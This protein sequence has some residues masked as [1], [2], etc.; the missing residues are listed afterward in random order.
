MLKSYYMLRK[1]R[2][3]HIYK[4]DQDRK[5][6]V[7]DKLNGFLTQETPEPVLWLTRL[8]KKQQQAITYKE[9][10]EAIEH[11]AISEARVAQWQQ[12]YASFVN[13]KLKPK[14]EKAIQTGAARVNSS[15]F[16]F[17]PTD[18]SIQAWI[19]GHGAQLVTNITDSQR[20][21]IN[22]LVSHSLSSNW[23]VDE[24]ARA[25]R[26]V[27]G[28][29]RPQAAANLRY[30]ERI[31]ENLLQQNPT[32]RL[33]TAGKKAQAAAHIYAQRQHQQRAYTIATTELAYAYN[34]GTDFA[35][36]QAMELGYIGRTMRIWS[37][38]RAERVCDIC[39]SLDG[40][41]IGMEDQFGLQGTWYGDVPPAHPHCRCAVLYHEVEP[42]KQ[43]PSGLLSSENIP[44]PFLNLPSNPDA[45]NNTEP[46]KPFVLADALVDFKNRLQSVPE[47]NRMLLEY[48]INSTQFVLNTKIDTPYGYYSKSDI[49]LYNPNNPYIWDYDFF[50]AMLHEMGHRLDY[51][52]VHSWENPDFI[53]AILIS[54]EKV[55]SNLQDYQK[56]IDSIEAFNNEYL[57]DIMSALSDDK[58]DT[59]AGHRSDYWKLANKQW[60]EVFANCFAIESFG[61]FNVLEIIK[62][63]FP[64]IY[65]TYRALMDEAQNI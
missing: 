5:R 8:W 40:A 27:I 45:R 2:H 51:L 39:G 56:K 6:S 65:N 18:Y 24:L 38:A 4:A 47:Q 43:S 12:E 50:T 16:T 11:R 10:R 15:G 42:P 57:A 20:E 14:W 53:N 23:T 52:M 49:I 32:M 36:K 55:K 61:A 63:E 58:L 29:T 37:T 26:P 46:Q 25:I 64:E 13:E 22:T 62:Q 33:E 41:I 28:L 9:I 30:Y 3:A 48:L 60:L 21:A 54:A 31:K 1:R 17:A 59:I 35:V 7:L 19:Q 44:E 34:K